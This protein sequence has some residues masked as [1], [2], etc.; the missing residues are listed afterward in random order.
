MTKK[1]AQAGLAP[2]RRLTGS[3]WLPS[4]VPP[5]LTERDPANG[6]FIAT[7]RHD[8]LPEVFI[9]DG[10]I[11]ETLE[12]ERACPQMVVLRSGFDAMR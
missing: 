9:R 12:N 4:S 7:R 3:G 10:L 5:I 6:S 1:A 8:T 11:I 2:K